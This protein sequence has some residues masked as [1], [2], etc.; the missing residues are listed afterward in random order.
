[1]N[2]IPNFEAR[3]KGKKFNDVDLLLYLYYE[4]RI[5]LNS[6]NLEIFLNV[7]KFLNFVKL[8]RLTKFQESV[9]PLN[10]SFWWDYQQISSNCSPTFKFFENYMLF[11]KEILNKLNEQCVFKIM[12]YLLAT[13]WIT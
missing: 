11:G 8:L 5:F 3:W 4:K 13:I 12:K 10:A 1:M 7:K 9:L 2:R 6:A